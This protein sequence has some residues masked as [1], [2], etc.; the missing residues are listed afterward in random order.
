MKPS[1]RLFLLCAALAGSAAVSRAAEAAPALNPNLPTIF[2]AGDSTAQVGEPNAVGWGKMFGSSIASQT[3]WLYPM[4]AIAVVCGLLWRRGRPRT[5]RLR[6]GFVLWGV[7]LATYFLVFSA[8][9]VGGHSYYM[10]VIAVPLAAL[11]GGGVTLLWRAYR[12]GGA[13]AWALPGTVAAGAVWSAY[14]AWQYPS[15]LPW[16]A[17]AVLVLGAAAVTVGRPHVYGLAL[18]GAG[19]VQAVLE[20]LVAELDLTLGLTGVRTVA[21]LGP[22]CLRRT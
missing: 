18:D 2:I 21:E 9:S 4:G 19:G 10:G 16:L 11:T 17:P 1:F 6:A 14:L 15:F 3:G 8:G 22:D 20:N 7:W 13:R 5:D 12:A